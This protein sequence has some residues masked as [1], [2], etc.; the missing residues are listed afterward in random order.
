MPPKQ[1]SSWPVL[2]LHQS[3][4]LSQGKI[5]TSAGL[6]LAAIQQ[7]LKRKKGV[8]C[9]ATYKA[10]QLY[11]S[12]FGLAEGPEELQNQHQL[13]PP[14]DSSPIYGDIVLVA[15]KDPKNFEA[16]VSFKPEQYEEFYTKMYDGGYDS[17][18]AP[19]EA[20]EELDAVVVGDEKEFGEEEEADEEVADEDAED[21]EEEAE[22]E[23]EAEEGG[24]E[25]G[26]PA[27]KT[28]SA[29]ASKKKRAAAK[30]STTLNGTGSAYPN[31]PILS[32]AEQLQEDAGGSGGAQES[33][34]RRKV[35]CALGAAFASHLADDKIADLE[36]SIY[37]GAIQQARVRHVVRTWSFPL[38]VHLYKMRAQ[39][40]VSNFHP[41]SYVGNTELYEGYQRGELTMEAIAKM[42]IYELFPSHWRTMFEAQQIREKKQL[43]GN[44]DRA[45]DQFTCTRCWKKQCT[46]YEMQTRS[47]DEPMTI[48]IT[49][50]NCG[51][52]WRQ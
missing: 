52:K 16:P 35:I 7:F 50:L 6:T 41:E 34:I 5:Q 11:L 10:K 40:V 21:A 3:G 38:F 32:E 44:M 2:V 18:E 49:C 47:A 25:E 13:P 51:K 23:A 24:D 36:R 26:A 4:E 22:E 46:Y 15:S 33:A 42:N 28:K 20:E 8:E 14:H 27:P 9:I 39:T 43:E 31:P 17:D 29:T 1:T 30:G 45:T 19:E 12:L 48:F 37:N